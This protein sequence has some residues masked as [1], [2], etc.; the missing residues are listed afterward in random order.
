MKKYKNRNLILLVSLVLAFTVLAAGCGQNSAEPVSE[1]EKTGNETAAEKVTV[2]LD[3]YP[4][5]NHTGLYVAAEKGF[6]EEQGLE[7]EIVQP[8]EGNTGEQL[9]AAGKAHF[10]I[11]AQE[12][13]TQA[14][15]N[16]IPLV[17]IAAIIQHNTSGFASLKEDGIESVKDFEGKTYGGWGSPVEE[18]VLKAVMENE[19]A[20]FSKLNIVTLGATDFFNSIGRDSDFQWIYYGWDGVE[21]ERRGIELNLLMLKDLDPALDYYTPVIITGE[22]QIAEQPELVK[23]FMAATAKGYEFAI[24]NPAESADIL[25]K[26]AP[27]LNGD[28]VHASQKWLSEQYQ[29]DASQ[30]GWQE[31]EVWERYARWM[32]ERELIPKMIEA[33]KAF[34]TEFLPGK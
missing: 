22:K 32:Y 9:V 31:K 13:V 8:G 18:A 2:M 33:D 17:S 15:A 25:L 34:T 27:E 30:W 1:N 6:Y 19:G 21:A 14:R 4:N 7:V 23:K 29:A 5:T 28:L 12:S 26:H 20:D 3:W 11:A 16:D 10:A 24:Q